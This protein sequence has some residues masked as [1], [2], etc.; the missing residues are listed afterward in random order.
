MRAVAAD[1]L[2]LALLEA[3]HVDDR[4]AEQE[5]EHQRGD[6]RAAGAEGDVAEDVEERDLTGKFGEPIEHRDPR[7][8][9]AA[10]TRAWR[11]KL[12]FQRLDDRPHFRAQRALH[13]HRVA[14]AEACEHGRLQRRRGLGIAAPRAGGKSLPERAHQRAGA[15]HEIDPGGGDRLGQSA[16][17]AAPCVAE[18]Q[19]VAEHGDAAAARAD[20]RLAEQRDRRPHRGRVGVVAFVDQQ[21]A[22][23]R[24]AERGAGAAA[25]RGLQLGERERG[26]REIGAGERAGRQHGER[27]EHQVPARRAEFVG[28][29]LAEDVGLDGRGVGLQSVT[30]KPRLGLRVLAEGDDAGDARL[31]GGGGEP[32]DIARCRG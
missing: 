29:V 11:G 8:S 4:A 7:P 14:G 13:H 24:H 22:A 3:Q 23:A 17:K 20:R 18:F 21:R 9:R 6:H 25:G 30:H 26:E 32:V 27:I 16:C 28:H 19:H 5:H 10:R 12:P 31:L 2:A 15:V 1:R